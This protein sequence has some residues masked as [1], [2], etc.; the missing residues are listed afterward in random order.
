MERSRLPPPFAMT[1][2]SLLQRL[3]WLSVAGLG[4]AV[5]LALFP[6]SA[7]WAQ[8]VPDDTLGDESPV[9]IPG[10][11]DGAAAEL[12]EAGAMRESNLFHSFLEFDVGEGQRVYFAS[13]LGI[14][15]ILSRVTGANPSNIF[16]TLG[17]A[18]AA[19][20]FLVNPNGIV[21]GENATLDIPGSFYGTTA[22]AFPW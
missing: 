6:V 2:F 11:I 12:I 18:G 22:I 10:E 9:V 20:L 15:S 8:I 5:G 16:G 19:D 13:P 1:S 17:V 14:E 3:R 4:S 21:F 7:A